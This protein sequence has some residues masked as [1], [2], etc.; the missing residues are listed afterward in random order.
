M[1]Q[2]FLGKSIDNLRYRQ[3]GLNKMT[4][5]CVSGY[6]CSYVIGILEI[7]ITKLQ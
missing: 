5:I 1:S 6:A 2:D 3:K 4:I 7:K